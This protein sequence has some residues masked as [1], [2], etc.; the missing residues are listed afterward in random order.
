M[1]IVGYLSRCFARPKNADSR[2]LL[3]IG[4]AISHLEA[5]YNEP[6]NLDRLAQIAHMSKRNFVRSF[7]AAMGNPPIAHLIQLRMTRGASLL[8]RTEHQVT[9]IAFMVGFSD[10]NYFTRQFIKHFG[11][12][13]SSYR[14]QHSPRTQGSG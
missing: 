3:R 10:S 8:R 12:A 7:K 11:V 6:I 4:A 2:A 1:Q 14:Q 5:N 9:E 13:P